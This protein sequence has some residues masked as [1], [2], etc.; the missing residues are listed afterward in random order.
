MTDTP[1]KF[2][3]LG[4]S[5]IFL[6]GSLFQARIIIL[7]G[8]LGTSI[9]PEIEDCTRAQGST[10]G[11]PSGRLCCTCSRGLSWHS[12]AKHAKKWI[13]C[14]RSRSA[15]WAIHADTHLAPKPTADMTQFGS[16][17][18]IPFHPFHPSVHQ[19]CKLYKIGECL[20]CFQSHPY[21]STVPD[22]TP[23]TQTLSQTIHNGS[24]LS[25]PACSTRSCFNPNHESRQPHIPL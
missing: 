1:L 9:R 16:R 13:V 15:F 8:L 12:S 19:P 18:T 2:A 25:I 6:C 14:F 3:S 7:G 22:C 11:N 10:C 20:R 4:A 17:H 24:R 5:A 23:H 21:R